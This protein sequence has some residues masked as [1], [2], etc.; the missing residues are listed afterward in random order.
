MFELILFDLDGTLTDPKEGITNCVKYALESFGITEND[1][2]KLLKFIGPPLYDSFRGIYN[3]SHSDALLA[4]EKYRERFTDIGILENSLF[5]D[6]VETLKTLKNAG[7]TVALATSKPFEFAERVLKNFEIYDYFDIAVGAEFDGTRGYKDE[8]ISEVLRQYGKPDL[9]KVLM[10]GDREND[11]LG[12]KKCKI[13]SAGVRCGYAEAGELE[14]AGAD[15]IFENLTDL[16]AFILE[17][18]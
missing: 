5:P 9:S 16:T 18:T 13:A 14:K 11:I 8:V 12:A 3:F 7:K 15:F 1:E 10:V 17:N 6:T 2:A 4:V